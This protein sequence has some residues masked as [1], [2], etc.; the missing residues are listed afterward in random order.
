MFHFHY[1]K[2]KKR[3]NTKKGFTL[4]E[5]L[6]AIF[7]LTLALT[8]PIYIATLA[9]RSSIESRDSISAYYLAEEVVEVIRNK[10]DTRSLSKTLAS[11]GSEWLRDAS[12]KTDS[13]TGAAN[14]FNENNDIENICIMVRDPATRQYGFSECVGGACEPLSFN[15]DPT[16]GI[17]YGD[18]TNLQ[19]NSK[20][21]REFYIETAAQD[22]AANTSTPVREVNLVVTV[23]WQD[24]GRDKQFQIV[25][26]LYNLQ[27]TQYEN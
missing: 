18:S 23:K 24:K 27:Y 12:P 8:G 10:R 16:N 7:L 22:P 13:V 26:R 2:I 4:L 17:I 14:C 1:K 15:S 11:D 5:T 19:T 6:I 20:F 3:L 9:L 25:E 21:T